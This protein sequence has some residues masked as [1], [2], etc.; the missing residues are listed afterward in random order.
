M[1]RQKLLMASGL[2]QNRFAMSDLKI[3]FVSHAALILEGHFGKLVCDPWIL[4]EPVFNLSTWKFPPA[5]LQPEDVAKDVDYLLITHSHEDH[6]H[7][8]SLHYFNRDVPVILSAFDKH[9]SLR[10]C[11]IELVLRKMGFHNIRKLR[12]WE[13]FALSDRAFLTAIPHADSRARDWENMGFVIEH[14]DCVFLNLND[15]VNDEALCDDIKTRFPVID[16]AMIQTGGVTMFPGCFRMPLEQKREEAQKR[17]LAFREQ[18]RLLEIIKPKHIAPFA[19]DF[20]WLAPQY[21]H[22]NWANRTT[23]ILFKA[24]LE[25]EYPDSELILFQP[26]DKWSKQQGLQIKY[27]RIQW[28]KMLDSMQQLQQLFNKKIQAIENYLHDVSLLNLKTRSYAYTK[29]IEKHI[30]RDYIDFTARFRMQIE[31]NDA[32]FSFVTKADPIN[33]FQIDWDD[34]APVDQTLYIKDH[35]WAAIV[36]G[37]LMWNIIQWVAEA[38]QASYRLDMGKLWFWMEYHIDLNNKNIQCNI[39]EKLFPEQGTY[40]DVHKAV[41]RQDDEA[42]L[43]ENFYRSLEP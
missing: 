4:N 13:R 19:G 12:S 14:P 23:P 6:F 8:P 28:E 16:L 24:M 1:R 29:N 42:T 2:L 21:F 37:K 10:A 32:P 18:R 7:I 33:Y 35:I 34:H 36:E 15:N 3:T 9:P 41:F 39:S 27:P 20:C 17:K 22:N 40:L 25:N 26:G 38:E 43:I 11:T 5:I 31:S 30:T